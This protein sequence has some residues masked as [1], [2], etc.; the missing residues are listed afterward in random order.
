MGDRVWLLPIEP[1]EGRYTEQWYRWYPEDLREDGWDVQMVVPDV[2]PIADTG[3]GEFLHPVETWRWKGA[4]VAELADCWSRIEDGDWILSLDGWG[5]A[6][7]AALYMRDATRKRVRVAGFM[8][9]GCWDPHDFLSRQGMGK[10]A[11][12]IESGWVRGLDLVLCGSE[13]AE[14]MMRTDLNIGFTGGFAPFAPIGNPIKADELRERYPPVP[15]KERL[16]TVCFPHRL[17]PEKDPEAFEEIAKTFY[18]LYPDDDA[19]FMRTRDICATKAQYYELLGSARVVV[20]TA[21]QETFGI[22]MQEGIALGAWAVAPN[23]LSYPETIPPHA[24]DLFRHG[25]NFATEAAAFIKASL[26]SD[27]GP[28]W[29]EYHENAVFR[30]SAAMRALG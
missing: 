28:V 5:P 17:A 2:P 1:F 8:H 9:A 26:D 24:G 19:R 21:K 7:T 18:A 12:H 10:W 13:F 6:T 29:D 16:R 27:D 14:G 15:W 22:A 23:R 3:G 25:P 30:A 20:S 11:K 4:Q